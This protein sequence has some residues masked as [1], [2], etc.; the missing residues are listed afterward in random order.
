MFICSVCIFLFMEKGKEVNRMD[1]EKKTEN[2][3]GVGV[4]GN[5][6]PN[7]MRSPEERR[8]NGRKGGLAY[9]ENKKRERDMQECMKALLS[10]TMSKKKASTEL[11]EYKDLISDNPTI[12]EILGLV[13]VREAMQGSSKAFEVLRDTAGY[14]PTEKTEVSATITEADRSL[15]DKVAKRTGIDTESQ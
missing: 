7:S 11:E 15:L 3:K 12:M 9:G 14:K 4:N 2:K 1:E 5:L 10:L 13:Q 6:I 8:A